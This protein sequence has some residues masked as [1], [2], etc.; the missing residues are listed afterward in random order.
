VPTLPVTPTQIA[1]AIALTIVGS[2]IQGNVGIGFAVVAGPILLLVNTAFV[3]APVVLAAMLLVLLIAMRERR[4]VIVEDLKYALL[5]RTIGTVPA[6]YAV[7]AFPKSAYELLFAALVII[8]V[9]LS[10]LGW[11][12]HR[13]R[14][15]VTLASIA[16]GFMST[17]SS[18]GGPPMALLYQNEE[19]PRIRATISAIFTVGGFITLAGLWWAGRFTVVE[20]LLGLLLMPGVIIGFAISGYTTAI[21]DRVELKPAILIISAISALAVIYKALASNF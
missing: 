10:A 1:I 8:G 2:A 17:V 12:I 9:V 4:D 19:G 18:M 3:P 11:H 14:R 15:N 21:A 5:G 20:L 7:K 16:S 13:T 6:A